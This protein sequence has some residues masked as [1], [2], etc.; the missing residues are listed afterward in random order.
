MVSSAAAA[1]EGTA[2]QV[3]PCLHLK[4]PPDAMGS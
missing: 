1:A 4:Q 2:F 3:P